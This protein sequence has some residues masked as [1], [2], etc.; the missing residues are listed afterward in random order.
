MTQ[1]DSRHTVLPPVQKTKCWH[2]LRKTYQNTA[3]HVTLSG[4]KRHERILFDS[5]SVLRLM[6]GVWDTPLPLH[7]ITFIMWEW[8][9]MRVYYKQSY[10]T[11][12]ALL[13]PLFDNAFSLPSISFPVCSAL[14][15]G[16]TLAMYAPISP[17]LPGISFPPTTRIPSPLPEIKRNRKF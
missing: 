9:I 1:L 17:L 2:R 8:N 16:K 6:E 14:P 7:K 10:C 3:H 5:F 4:Y 15:P 11:P 12:N 13:L